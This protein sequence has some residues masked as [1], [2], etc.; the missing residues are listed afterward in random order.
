M[1]SE[2]MIRDVML[3]AYK[4]FGGTIKGKTLLQKRVYFLTV[5]LNL[6]LGYEAHYYGPYSEGVA[7]ANLE[8]KSLGYVSESVAAWGVDKRGF[9]IS[10]YDY[11][12]TEAGARI[13]GRKASMNP[14]L[15]KRI[16]ASAK[17]VIDAGNLDYMEL[18]IAAKAYYILT[19]LKHK[20][21]LEDIG[22]MLPKFGWKVSVEELQRATDFLQKTNL[23]THV[24]PPNHE[25]PR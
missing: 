21:T 2:Q 5:F 17:V 8:M 7:T 13:A 1:A 22:S 6:D 23:V 4:A 3:L 10:R 16:E 9:E 24:R 12:L 15:W 19:Q 25:L 14:Q 18:S 11:T 20:A